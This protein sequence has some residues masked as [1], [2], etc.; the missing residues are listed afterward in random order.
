MKTW[1]DIFKDKLKGREIPL[2]E[3]SLAEFRSKLD[4]AASAPTEKRFP[5]AW[6][7]AAAVAA[8][9]AAILFLRKPGVSE[10]GIQIIHQ[11]SAH[12]AIVTDSTTV[13]EPEQTTSLI[14]QVVIQ[15]APRHPQVI[16]SDDEKLNP[17]NETKAPEDDSHVSEPNKDER[18]EETETEIIDDKTAVLPDDKVLPISE[19]FLQTVRKPNLKVAPAAGG[20]LGTSALAALATTLS[21]GNY[22]EPIIIGPGGPTED[23]VGAHRHYFPVKIGLQT[24]IPIA[25]SLYLST[26]I[27]YS[28]YYSKYSYLISGEKRQTAHYIGIPVH[29]DYVIASNNRFDVYLGAGMQGDYCLAASLD[30]NRI[31]KDT[32]S[33]SLLGVGGIQMNVSK[34][35]GLYIEP[36]LSWRI[37]I[38]SYVLET[39]RNDRP[40][41]FTVSAGLRFSPWK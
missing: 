22:E 25:K 31:Q 13:D 37:P 23:L 30:G 16:V 32:P 36:G 9:L 6:A 17:L 10:E 1:E 15:K 27:E 29:L 21:V 5:V 24:W 7:L 4:G 20:L 26:G 11:P 35:I 19:S 33:I 3:E 12:I 38:D 40:V 39:Y 28:M 18:L 2:P 41:S 34:H 8:G 14:A